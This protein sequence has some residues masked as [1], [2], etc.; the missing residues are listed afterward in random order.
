MQKELLILKVAALVVLSL[1]ISGCS[2]AGA[3]QT[4]LTGKGVFPQRLDESSGLIFTPMGLFSLSDENRNEFYRV[5][6]ANAGIVQTVT[7]S[8][9]S[10]ADTEA[11]S[12]DGEFLYIGDFGNNDGDRKDLK[13]IKVKAS[14]I[15]NETTTKARGE[16]IE[17]HYPEQTE[18][19]LKK[20]QNDFDCEAMVISGDSIYLFTKQRSDHR[21][22]LYALPAAPGKHAAIKKAVFDAK[23]R[24][25]D[26]AISPDGNTL[27]LLG[28]QKKHQY[29]FVWKITESTG[30]DFFTGHAEYELLSK[31]PL[32]WQTEGISFID[33]ESIFI[34]CESTEDVQASLYHVRLS[35]LFGE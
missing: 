4:P 34:S 5:D 2:S 16:A 30:G 8:G 35:T 27:L 24:I 1:T 25:T 11:I 12:Y 17:F 32:D 29:P 19:D 9:H 18:F 21:T 6:T 14:D 13:I 28:Y 10:F 22:T 15:S 23:G 31:Y 3:Q 26:A 7:V 20:G 33:N